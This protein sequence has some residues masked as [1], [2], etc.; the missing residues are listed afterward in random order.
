MTSIPYFFTSALKDLPKPL[1]ANFDLLYIVRTGTGTK[2]AIELIFTIIP[3]LRFIIYGST[4][5]VTAM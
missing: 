4:A 5:L 2:P 1:S 3:D